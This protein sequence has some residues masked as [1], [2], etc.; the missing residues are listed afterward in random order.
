MWNTS[1]LLVGLRSGTT[2]LENNLEVSQKIGKETNEDPGIQ[3]VGINMLYHI[4]RIHAPPCSQQVY[5]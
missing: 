2:T 5:K 1:P 3:L 4:T